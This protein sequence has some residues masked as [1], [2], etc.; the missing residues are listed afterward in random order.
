VKAQNDQDAWIADL[1]KYMVSEVLEEWAG[2]SVSISEEAVPTTRMDTVFSHV[3]GDCSIEVQFRAEP[4]VF[5]QMARNILEEEP[6]SPEE[7]REFAEEFFNVLCGRFIAEICTARDLSIRLHPPTY[8]TADVGA[9]AI[10][11][12]EPQA[13]VFFQT[14]QK[15]LAEFSWSHSLTE[16]LDTTKKTNS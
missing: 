15:E 13:A 5:Y 16:L 9:R 1:A 8:Q 7:V 2:I 6:E 11:F 14:D 12:R 4:S 10:G 3:D